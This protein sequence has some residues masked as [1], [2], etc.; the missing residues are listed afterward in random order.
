MFEEKTN[1]GSVWRKWDLQIHTPY[2]YLN[3]QFGDDFDLYVKIVFKKALENN[4]SVIG[5]TDYFC[6]EGYKKIKNGYLNNR[7]SFKKLDFTD[8]EIEKIQNILILPNIEFRLNKFVGTNRINFHVVFSNKIEVRDI[9]ENFLHELDFV[10]EGTPQEKDEMMKLKILNLEKLGKKLKR[11]HPTFKKSDLFTGMKNAVVDDKQIGDILENKKS[12]FQNSY[13]TFVPADEDLSK[14]SWDGQDHQTRKVILQKSSGLFATNRGTI[15][16]GL[17]KKHDCQKKF[18]TEFKTLKPCVCGSDAHKESGLFQRKDNR[19]CWI[20]ADPTFEG[21]Q[22]IIYD[23]EDRVR[24]QELKPEDKSDYNIIDRVEYTNAGE[25]KIIEFNQNLNSIIGSRATGKSNLLKN[26]AYSIDS[27]QCQNKE[28]SIK[29]FYNFQNFK[30]FWKNGLTNNLNDTK[31]ETNEPFEIN[32]S[33][34]NDSKTSILFIPQGYLGKIVY[35]KGNRFKDFV[36]SLFKNIPEF[37]EEIQKYGIFEKNN[38]VAITSQIK[39][40]IAIRNLGHD[41]SVKKKKEG[42]IEDINRDINTLQQNIQLLIKQAGQIKPEDINNYQEFDKEKTKKENKKKIIQKNINSFELLKTEDV[43]TNENISEFEFSD[44]YKE[45]IQIEIKK[46]DKNFKINFIEIE[47]EKLNEKILQEEKE[48]K[49]IEIKLNPLKKKI[50]DNK[51]ILKIS[52]E[53]KKKE[54]TK[55]EVIQLTNNI[56]SLREAYKKEQEK[57][58]E[59]YFKFYSEYANFEFKIDDLEFSKFMKIIDFDDSDFLEFLEENIN[60]HNS[61]EFKE[62]TKYKEANELLKNPE[63]FEY[64]KIN[65]KEILNQLFRGIMLNSLLLKTNKNKD[66]VLLELFKN[67]FRINYFES[68]TQEGIRFDNMSDGEKMI[69][70]LE[71]IFKFDGCNY[72]ILIDQPEDDLDVRAISRYIVEFIKK[73]K[74]KRQIFIVSHNAN[75]VVCSDSEEIIVANKTHKHNFKYQTGAIENNKIRKEIIDVLEGGEDAIKKM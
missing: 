72:P 47:I 50:Q 28:V 57:I 13:L 52:E 66:W 29:D 7:E 41:Y 3:T 4:I 73:Q 64:K 40:L 21:L 63:K 65:F 59:N 14:I 9:E 45:K 25:K 26:I 20:K 22:Q 12:I 38:A 15:E 10:Y 54:K 8:K 48:L 39:N 37:A 62:E 23:P 24:I 60:Y 61:K 11:E 46:S 33:N 17:G 58:T 27:I 43:I 67:R 36:V 51:I 56:S 18:I 55:Q 53:L 16:W 2:S 75:L 68:I 42:N 31:A 6:I 74:I 71:F 34:S 35:S 5:I 49:N 32:S 19:F 30:L 1:R 69:V 44:E 70:L